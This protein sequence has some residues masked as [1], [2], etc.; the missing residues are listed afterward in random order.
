MLKLFALIAIYIVLFLYMYIYNK[1]KTYGP[2]S[3]HIKKLM[4]ISTLIISIFVIGYKDVI[5]VRTIG[6]FIYFVV[7]YLLV[8]AYYNSKEN[9]T[10]ASNDISWPPKSYQDNIGNICPDYWFKGKDK[11]SE[12]VCINKF[13][14]PIND[15]CFDDDGGFIKGIHDKEILLLN[16][17][18]NDQKCN[19][20]KKCGV[21][22]DTY[23]SWTGIDKTCGTLN[24]INSDDETA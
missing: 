21:R 17:E 15:N 5:L 1:I 22:E 2:S 18:S 3:S 23:A 16:L 12:D 19:W 20:I 24:L 11:N 14:I 6:F 4:I 7:L 8:R 13:N 9:E 10:L